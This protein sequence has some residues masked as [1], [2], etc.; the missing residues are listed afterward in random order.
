M[1]IV[2][3]QSEIRD[4]AVS[5][6]YQEPFPEWVVCK[7]CDNR[8]AILYLLVND[9]DQELLSERPIDARVWPHDSSTVAIYLCTACGSMRA[10]WNQG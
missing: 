10:R 8:K 2:F 9:K 4:G 1:E 6:T 7:K 3:R 5:E